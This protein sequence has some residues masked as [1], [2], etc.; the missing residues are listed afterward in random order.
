LI[1]RGLDFG[2]APDP[3]A[4]LAAYWYN[5][6]GILDEKLYQT[7]LINE[8]LATSIKAQPSPSAPIVA[9]SAEP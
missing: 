8:H 4:V 9:D 2:F 5:G 7:Q 6:G 3:A 1:G